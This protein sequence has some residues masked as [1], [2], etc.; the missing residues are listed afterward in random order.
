MVIFRDPVTLLQFFG[1]S[2][3]LSG[4]VYYKLGAEKFRELT[5]QARQMWAEKGFASAN[6][7]LLRKVAVLAGIVIFCLLVLSYFLPPALGAGDSLVDVAHDAKL[8]GYY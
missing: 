8:S 6:S 7:A 3:A 5:G 1:Y 2:I 4:L